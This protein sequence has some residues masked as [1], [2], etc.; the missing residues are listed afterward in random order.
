MIK[1]CILS[2]VIIFLIYSVSFPQAPDNL[3]CFNALID[4][5]VNRINIL[6]PQNEGISIKA[7]MP[8]D[9]FAL[10]GTVFTNFRARGREI[11]TDSKNVRND[12]HLVLSSA[13][14]HYS[15]VFRTK[16]FG[17]FKVKR[18]VSLKGNYNLF[19]EGVITGSEEI[20]YS[21]TDTIKYDDIKSLENSSLPYT[22]GEIPSEPFF[23]SLLEPAI[24]VSAA[25]LT[26]ILFFTVRSK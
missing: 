12:L 4:S 9:Y 11:H 20:N 8:D 7:E 21:Y 16:L 5:A 24:A 15:D 26:I 1:T 23:S 25:A 10:R 2:I 19:R 13:R 14:V 18:I 17:D 22:K 6:I 3:T